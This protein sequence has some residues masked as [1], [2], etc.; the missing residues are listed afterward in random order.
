[1]NDKLQSGFRIGDWEVYPQENL[2]KRPDRASVLEPKV[3]DVLVFLAG[4]QGKVVSRQQLLD[5]VWAGVVVG[6]ET[7][8]RAIS[9]LRAE[10]GDDHTNSR[11]VKTISKRGSSDASEVTSAIRR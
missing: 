4:R 9:V 3:M 6:D 5:A 11:Y 1:M 8:S 2:L 7:L 10:L